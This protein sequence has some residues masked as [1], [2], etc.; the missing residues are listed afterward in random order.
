MHINDYAVWAAAI[1]RVTEG[2]APDRE[3]M[4]YLG[5]GLASEAGEIVGH[6]KKL[7]RDG[8]AA[9]RPEAIGDELGDLA[10]YWAAL[11]VAI[12]RSPEAVLAA[13][14]TKIERR[15]AAAGQEPAG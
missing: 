12:G 1:A 5:L 6:I 7:L 9:W 4:S 13:S 15:I 14:R 11:C 3:R 10:Y 2:G 8:E